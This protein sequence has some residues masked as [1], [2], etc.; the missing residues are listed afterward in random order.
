[1]LVLCDEEKFGLPLGLLGKPFSVRGRYDR[2]YSTA[3]EMTYLPKVFLSNLLCWNKLDATLRRPFPN[4]LVH[5]KLSNVIYRL[6]AR[7]QRYGGSLKDQWGSLSV[8]EPMNCASLVS[9]HVTAHFLD[10]LHPQAVPA[11][12]SVCPTLRGVEH[13]SSQLSSQLLVCLQSFINFS[14]T[15]TPTA[16]LRSRIEP[17]PLAYLH[18]IPP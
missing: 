18:R 7:D 15:Q 12:I 6:E 16:K 2:D 9:L 3:T 11:K 1:M 10:S 13:S 17:K 14:D 5:V 8:G 4:M